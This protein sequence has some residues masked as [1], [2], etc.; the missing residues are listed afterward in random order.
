MSV[1]SMFTWYRVTAIARKE[2]LQIIRNPIISIG[3]IF[4]PLL[5]V[6]IFAAL[7]NFKPNHLATA[8]IAN[9]D[10]KFVHSIT[11]TF[12][13][14]H[15]FDIK[16]FPK[17]LPEAEHLMAEG[18]IRFIINMLPGFSQKI[19][20]GQQPDVLLIA[21]YSNPI[22]VNAAISAASAA[23]KQ[24]LNFDMQGPL[25]QNHIVKPAVNLIVHNRYNPGEIPFYFSIPVVLTVIVS[26][27]LSSY[28][29]DSIVTEIQHGTMDS[30]LVTPACSQEVLLAKMAPYLIIGILQLIIILFIAYFFYSIPIR[31]NPIL[32]IFISLPTLIASILV[33]LIFSIFSKNEFAAIE[34]GFYHMM[35]NFL[36]TGLALPFY[37][38]PIWAQWIGNILP[39]T[40]LM[41]MM[42]S[43][44]L[45]GSSFAE[46]WPDFWPTILFMFIAA[47]MVVKKYRQKFE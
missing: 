10:S 24:S 13:N 6:I 39:V 20:R 19:T 17:S 35:V 31:S 29:T 18:K 23:M 27:A 47:W 36:F 8:L 44:T 30:L 11:Q 38:M 4:F 3:M 43:L 14:T 34:L 25:A 41:R 42:L 5:Q 2:F 7:F 37:G 45:K 21:D 16:V 22:E 28:A 12:I 32:I 9:D 15:Y 26:L 33:G 1:K 40:H 46:I